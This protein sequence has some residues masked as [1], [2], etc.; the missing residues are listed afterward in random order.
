MGG[1]EGRARCMD[2]PG[3]GGNR[4]QNRASTGAEEIRTSRRSTSKRRRMI[5]SVFKSMLERVGE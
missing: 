5:R 2:A 4:R 3:F 1:G